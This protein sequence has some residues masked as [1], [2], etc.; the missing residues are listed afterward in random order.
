LKS[1]PQAQRARILILEAKI[2]SLL[3]QLSDARRE[4]ETLQSEL[5]R[6]YS[7]ADREAWKAD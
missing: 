7:D 2:T 4:Q 6:L 1:D 5:D 3:C